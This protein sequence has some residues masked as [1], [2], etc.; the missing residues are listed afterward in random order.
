MVNKSRRL[1]N[2]HTK[3]MKR[4]KNGLPSK[5]KKKEKEED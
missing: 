3:M 5:R 2:F 4:K 1:A